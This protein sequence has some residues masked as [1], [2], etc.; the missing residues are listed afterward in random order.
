MKPLRIYLKNFANHNETEVDCTQFDSLLIVGKKRDD[1]KVSNGVGKSTIFDAVNY[2]FFNVPPDDDLTL[3]NVVRDG[4][5]K[6]IVEFDF[7]L[8]HEVYRVHRHRT[9]KGSADLRLYQCKG[10]FEP[11]WQPC[12]GESISGRTPTATEKKLQELIKINYKS[13]SYSVLFSQAD[14]TGISNEKNPKKRKEMM[15]EPMNL[16]PYAKLQKIVDDKAKPIKKDIDRVEAAVQM[17]GDPKADLKQ[18]K[19]D[20]AQ[21]K[22]D[23]ET[24]QQSVNELVIQLKAK[25]QAHQDLKSSLGKEDI[26]I[27][28]KVTQQERKV[29]DLNKKIKKLDGAI[30]QVGKSIDE[31]EAKRLKIAAEVSERDATLDELVKVTVRPVEEIV[32]ELDKVKEDELKGVK[33][34]AVLQAEIKQADERVPEDDKCPTCHQP[35]TDEYRAEHEEHVKNTIAEKQMKLDRFQKSLKV[36]R[37]KKKRLEEE[38]A[39]NRNNEAGITNLKLHIKHLRNEHDTCQEQWNVSKKQIKEMEAELGEHTAELQGALKHFNMLKD[40]AG[41]SNV[42]DINNKIFALMDEIRLFEKSIDSMRLEVSTLKA[43]EGAT[44]ERIKTRTD[45]AVKLVEKQEKLAKLEEE[46]EVH[47]RVSNAFSWRGIPTFIIQ[48]ILDEL[49]LETNKA[50]Q[51]LR[52]ELEVK[53]DAELNMEFKRNGVAKAY[54]Q[55]S[56]G[57]KVY[58]ALAFKRGMSRVMQ[59]RLGLDIRMLEFDEVDAHLDEAG[60]EA[61]ADAI[62]KWKSEFKIFVVTHNRNL[63]DKFTHAMLVEES[64][65][66][67]EGRLVDTW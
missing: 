6:A 2:V 28:D 36:C 22:S 43:K 44:E 47:K 51:E 23:I 33:L 18:A 4:K 14:L 59:R 54:G 20:L 8:N 31:V 9:T 45:D 35:I 10:K 24:K 58:I 27:H 56:H 30:I 17:L 38:W 53:M 34:I 5:K 37:T 15:K 25:Q 63:K 40:A 16:S 48:T 65:D 62:N 3:D 29:K 42:A 67:A 64:D 57:Q 61:F 50:L 12:K 11:G 13:F 41:K 1:D 66:G 60:Q 39:E 49:Q 7:E 46:L 19:V 21:C 32:T 26:D 52:P 55:L